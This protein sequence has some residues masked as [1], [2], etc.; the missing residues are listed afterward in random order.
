MRAAGVEKSGRPPPSAEGVPRKRASEGFEGGKED[1]CSW[2]VQEVGGSAT[3]LLEELHPAG[4]GRLRQ[5]AR[6]RKCYAL[7]G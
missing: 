1:L 5:V 2:L 4:R 6:R 7:R 3:A